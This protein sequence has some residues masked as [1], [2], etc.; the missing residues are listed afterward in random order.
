[1]PPRHDGAVRASPAWHR[2]DPGHAVL[3]TLTAYTGN[4]QK[5]AGLCTFFLRFSPWRWCA[6]ISLPGAIAGKG[7]DRDAPAE[8]THHCPPIAPSMQVL[9]P[10]APCLPRMPARSCV[11][12]R[13]CGLA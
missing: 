9:A 11:R 1:M 8:E 6:E 4:L 13:P 3:E 12:G 5:Q 10:L 2:D 7:A